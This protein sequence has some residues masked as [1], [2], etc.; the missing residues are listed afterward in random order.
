MRNHTRASG[1][2][3]APVAPFQRRF[4][5]DGG[6]CASVPS[7]VGQGVGTQ[8]RRKLARWLWIGRSYEHWLSSN[9]WPDGSLQG[10]ATLM[11]PLVVSTTRT[12]L[13][14]GWR[15]SGECLCD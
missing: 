12:S 2:D 6:V 11:Q 5:L 13:R 4:W 15:R 10:G 8:V 14:I 3:G 7:W 1:A 9:R